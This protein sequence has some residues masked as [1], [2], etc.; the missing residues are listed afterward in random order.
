MADP[1]LPTTLSGT[2]GVG[3]GDQRSSIEER[4]EPLVQAPET[5]PVDA[6]LPEV[7]PEEEN[8]VIND[9]GLGTDDAGD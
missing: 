2:H 6:V 4:H 5:L 3:H 9:T 7:K 8:S 1:K